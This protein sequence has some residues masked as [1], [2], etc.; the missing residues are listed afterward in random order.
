MHIW[1]THVRLM[2]VRLMHRLFDTRF[3]EWCTFD[4]WFFLFQEVDCLVALVAP[5]LHCLVNQSKC[6]RVSW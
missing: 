5:H 2:H 4:R 1:L 6:V 3:V